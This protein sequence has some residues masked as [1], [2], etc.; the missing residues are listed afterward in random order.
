M[1]T[2]AR[3]AVEA[4]NLSYTYPDR[5]INFFVIKYSVTRYFD[6]KNL[7]MLL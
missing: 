6:L 1:G 5:G 3:V 7:R 4:S 2:N